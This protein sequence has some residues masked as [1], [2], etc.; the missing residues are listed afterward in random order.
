MEDAPGERRH[1]LSSRRGMRDWVP[2]RLGVR[3]AGPMALLLQQVCMR[4]A[5][6]DVDLGSCHLP[7][8][9]AKEVACGEL[10]VEHDEDGRLSGAVAAGLRS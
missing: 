10:V 2:S 5:Q 8:C 7:A 1:F 3:H 6:R 9:V 4:D